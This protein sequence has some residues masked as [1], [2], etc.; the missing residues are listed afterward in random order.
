MNIRLLRLSAC[1]ITQGSYG[2][3]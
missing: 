2:S 1:F 3:R